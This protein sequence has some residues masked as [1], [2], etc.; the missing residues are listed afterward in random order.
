[1]NA[2]SGSPERGATLHA[3]KHNLQMDTR[4][5]TAFATIW[6][7]LH[8]NVRKIVRLWAF[9]RYVTRLEQLVDR[10]WLRTQKYS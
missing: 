4:N 3:F 8:L 9:L 7:Q 2:T 5:F 1:M 10:L 6:S